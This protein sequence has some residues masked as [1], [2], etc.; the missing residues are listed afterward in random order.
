[1]MD[2]KVWL[3]EDEVKNALLGKLNVDKIN[4][5]ST[6]LNTWSS[7]QLINVLKSLGVFTS[8]SKETQDNAIGKIRSGSGTL[9]ELIQIMEKK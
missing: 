8:L 4:S 1:M 5:L 6:S 2:F 7:E 9:G 3:E